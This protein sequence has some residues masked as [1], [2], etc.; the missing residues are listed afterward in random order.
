MSN[1]KIKVLEMVAEGKISPEEGVRLIEALGEAD[2]AG[3]SGNRRG[4]PLDLGDV[5]MPRI[6]LGHLGQ[7]YVE[8]K[9]SVTEGA[10]RAQNQLRRS[11]AGK[12]FE[13]RDYPLEIEKP[14]NADRCK[15]RLDIRAGRLKLKGQDLAEKLLLGKVKRAPEA[16]T[17][18]TELRD[19]ES[20]ITLRHSLGR[21]LL[22]T[23]TT[24]PYRI[25]LDNSAADSRLQLENVPVP[26]LNIENNAGSVTAVLGELL[27]RVVVSVSNNAGN[28]RLKVPGSHAI[29][30]TPSGTLSTDNLENHGLAT[31]DGVAASSD[32]ETNPKGVVIALSQNVA[33]FKLDWNR[34][35]GVHMADLDQQESLDELDNE[36]L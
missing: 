26:E 16:P 36:D 22:R 34:R 33:S 9:K 24:V 23:N 19:G 4:F 20:D 35:D 30:V 15:L 18:L 12:F 27:D 5:R 6:D 1:E 13:F 14:Q 3:R 8:L 11:R 10:R 31:I 25:H 7:V 2:R 32:W 21:C 17:V 28:V 29:K